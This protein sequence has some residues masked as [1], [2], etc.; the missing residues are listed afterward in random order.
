[1]LKDR[2]SLTAQRVALSR[3]AHQLY[4]NPR[5]LEDPVA[6]PIVGPRGE[7]EIRNHRRRFAAPLAR[8]LRA[9]LV[10]RS[11]VAEEALGAA[12][13]RGV[14]QYVVLGAGLDTF[15]FRNPYPDSLLRVFEVDHPVTQAWKRRQL[16]AA[17]IELPDSLT[18][19]PIDFETQALANVLREAGLRTDAPAFVSWLGVTMYLT[20][21]TVMA[22]LKYVASSLP[23]GSA[24]VFDYAVPPAGLG[25]VRRLAARALL[26]R[27][28]AAG[29][30][31]KAL[32]APGA[33]AAELSALGFAQIE[34][35]GPDELD[36]RFFRNRKDGLRV[37]GLGRV[38]R[39]QR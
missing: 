19:V 27:V 31:W 34:D 3:A 2:P 18:F 12:V 11:R 38:L 37:G 1:V 21:A 32:F 7:E 9:F 22:T 25:L 30:P 24:I 10:A 23:E 15:A 6:L 29:E 17:G 14:R 26:G 5:I 4:D 35:L 39:A 16:A 33:L 36:A 28:A 13:A 8:R 20:P